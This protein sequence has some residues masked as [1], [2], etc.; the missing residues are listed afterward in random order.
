MPLVL[1][2]IVQDQ[3]YFRR[4]VEP[5]IDGVDVRYLGS[6]GPRVRDEVLGG[7]RALLHPIAFEEPFGLSVVEAMAC[8]TPVVAFARGSMPE[9]VRDGETGFLVES[10]DAAVDAV[11][12]IDRVDRAACRAWVESRFSRERMVRDY[13]EVYKRVLGA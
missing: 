3:E 12:R 5:F 1:A 13:L 8:G 6:V 7:A 4:E 9:V 2:G 11:E 10:V